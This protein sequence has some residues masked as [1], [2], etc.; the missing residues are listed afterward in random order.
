MALWVV[1][2]GGDSAH[3]LEA[4]EGGYVGIGWGALGD[5]TAFDSVEKLRKHYGER[6]PEEKQKTQTTCSSQVFSFAHRI[7]R[8]DLVALPLKGRRAIAFGWIVG[9]YEFVPGA[10]RYVAHQRKVK[11]IKDPIPRNSIPQDLLYTLGAFLTVF[12][13]KRN[14]AETRIKQILDGQKDF[15][16]QAI[17]KQID[18]EST[19]ETL[20]IESI[21]KDQISKLIVSKFSGHE[22]ARLIGEVLK[23]QGYSTLVSPE[24][25]DGGVDVLAGS[26]PSG[27][28]EPKIAVQVKS[29][30]VVVDAPTVHRLQGT[31]KNFDASYGLIVSW[32]GF[33]NAALKEARR[34][35]F[36]IQM[37]DAD[38]VI[39]HLTENYDRLSEEIK[40]E[41]PLKRIWTVLSEEDSGI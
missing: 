24:G 6:F 21:T 38:D 36:S 35:F 2:C 27:F 8:G 12:Q 39:R 16:Q 19:E 17:T 34:L 15:Y 3:E 32:G 33:N 11:W 20:D 31:M 22:F 37:W 26:G 13:A 10:H 25:P 7:N 23:A 41:I 29:G 30:G 4:L 40:S 18:D 9:D 14:D 28:E 1:R 5:V